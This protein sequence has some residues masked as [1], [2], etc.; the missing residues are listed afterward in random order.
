MKLDP[1]KT[2]A[3]KFDQI[4]LRLSVDAQIIPLSE[5][6]LRTTLSRPDFIS[7]DKNQIDHSFFKPEII[8][9]LDI[10]ISVDITQAGI[11]ISVIIRVPCRISQGNTDNSQKKNQHC[12]FH[13]WPPQKE[14]AKS[15]PISF[16]LEEKS[17][18]SLE[19]DS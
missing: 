18:L 16:P 2:F 12:F 7:L 11:T 10:H 8:C 17:Q 19:K 4:E 9:P 6:D 5:V 13:L 14:R 1:F 3:R 15:M